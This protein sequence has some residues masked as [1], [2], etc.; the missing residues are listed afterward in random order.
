MSRIR[1]GDFKRAFARLI[2]LTHSPRS[3]SCYPWC[4]EER[5]LYKRSRKNKSL[6]QHFAAELKR[7]YLKLVSRFI[8]SLRNA[9]WRNS[10]WTWLSLCQ[11]QVHFQF[12]DKL[13]QTEVSDEGQTPDTQSRWEEL[14]DQAREIKTNLSNLPDTVLNSDSTALFS[15]SKWRLS[16]WL[17]DQRREWGSAEIHWHDS[18][19]KRF[20]HDHSFPIT[21]SSNP[22]CLS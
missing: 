15:H 20:D 14:C 4:Y 9:Q 5:C 17:E 10:P 3:S 7:K 18:S 16:G 12:L 21:L 22:S 11:S 2:W 1:T 19:W 13:G 8:R 6:C